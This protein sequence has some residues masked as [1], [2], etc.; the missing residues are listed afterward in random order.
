M[1]LDIV[2]NVAVYG[3]PIVLAGVGV[4]VTIYPPDQQNKRLWTA[5]MLGFCVITLVAIGCQQY[6]A[7]AASGKIQA[8]NARQQGELKDSLHSNELS[9]QY[10]RGQL[11]TMA[12]VL[13][14]V[15]TGQSDTGKI[16]L[17]A[18]GGIVKQAAVASDTRSAIEKMSNPVLRSK[19]LQLTKEMIEWAGKMD[20][21]QRIMSDQRMAEMRTIGRTDKPKVDSAWNAWNLRDEQFFSNY[22]TEF[23]RDFLG[24]ALA[25]RDELIR[26]LGPQ[27]TP[28]SSQERPLALEGW[29]A[30]LSV[31]WTAAY[32]QRLA[33]KLPEN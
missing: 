26:R 12:K 22:Q 28:N 20:Q 2:L 14:Q 18:L 15:A 32:L 16:M 9:N 21:A 17:S 29:I 24:A 23:R 11:D 1:L 31:P 13:G 30:P 27:P 4:Y 33:Y 5:S 25:Y 10:L 8:D 3:L 19:T 7:T 6:R